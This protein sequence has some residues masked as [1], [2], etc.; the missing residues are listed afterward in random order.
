MQQAWHIF[1]KDVRY[2]QREIVL[3]LALALA[4]YWLGPSGDTAGAFG[5]L[6]AAAAAY[7]IAK[8]I[9]AEAIPGDKQF[10]LTR[11]YR[12]PSLLLAKLLFILAFVNLPV[13]LAQA[14]ILL[15]NHFPIASIVPGLI[16]TQILIWICVALPLAVVAALTNGLAPFAG[17]IL[18]IAF[19]G[20]AEFWYEGSLGMFDHPLF[21]TPQ[22]LEWLRDGILFLAFALLAPII[23]YLQY[24]CR[25]TRLSRTL[26]AGVM[27]LCA[28]AYLMTPW[29]AL[30][31]IQ[32][33][34]SERTGDI[35]VTR[36]EQKKLEFARVGRKLVFEVPALISRLSPDVD[37]QIEGYAASLEAPDG[38]SWKLSPHDLILT[39]DAPGLTLSNL[40]R[41]RFSPDLPQS[42]LDH[43]EQ[44]LTLRLSFYFTLF[45]DT[46]DRTFT[47]H[48]KPANVMD[49]IQCFD[50]Y[51]NQLVCRSAFR[52]PRAIVS[53]VSGTGTTSLT[54]LISYSPFPAGLDIGPIVTKG[55]QYYAREPLPEDRPVT[56]E[57]K[58]P[59]AYVRRDVVV[60]DLR[61][62][63][64]TPPL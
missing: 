50:G 59:V 40:R 19:L 8:L 63:A 6:M 43:P 61:F 16:W 44:P 46:R 10:W 41:G 9:H 37:A 18:V 62:V 36:D 1:K 48:R 4:L 26:A 21:A 22:S 42:F 3:L 29:P 38:T 30:F 23:L 35:E 17:C 15:T 52:W 58:E 60:K 45:G 13:L 51:L 56:I 28:L 7:T 54:R 31:P 12:W 2:L 25:R 5:L 64:A 55:T 20:S 14:A 47:L 49:G 11:P 34:L 24:K 33:R 39:S 27:L 32:S 53:Q 57:I